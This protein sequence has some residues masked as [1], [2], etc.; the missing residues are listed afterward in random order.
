[1]VRSVPKTA[2][3]HRFGLFE[4]QRIGVDPHRLEHLRHGL[5]DLDVELNFRKCTGRPRPTRRV[6]D[7]CAGITPP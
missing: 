3:S 5:D 7:E 6:H 2:G 1:M 4:R